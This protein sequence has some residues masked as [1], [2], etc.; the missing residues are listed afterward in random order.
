MIQLAALGSKNALFKFKQKFL[1]SVAI[2]SS[3]ASQF[4]SRSFQALC[5]HLDFFEIES[6]LNS[7]LEKDNVTNEEQELFC[8]SLQSISSTNMDE[9][10][11]VR[12][13]S[14]S[15]EWNDGVVKEQMSNIISTL[16]YGTNISALIDQSFIQRLLSKP[17]SSNWSLLCRLSASSV[18]H[19]VFVYENTK[20]LK[21]LDFDQLIQ[22]HDAVL[23][24]V[25]DEVA[26]Q[27]RAKSP[28]ILLKFTKKFCKR[29]FEK[30]SS[31]FLQ[32]LLGRAEDVLF[33]EVRKVFAFG[34]AVLDDTLS[35]NFV[36]EIKNYIRA[37]VENLNASV[38]VLSELDIFTSHL[39]A[40]S[41]QKEIVEYQLW[42]ICEYFNLRKRLPA[43]SNDELVIE[44][45]IYRIAG[46]A[47]TLFNEGYFDAQSVSVGLVK[48]VL[49]SSLKFR[50]Q[51]A[52]IITLLECLIRKCTLEDP[53]LS[54][55]T[56]VTTHSAF[57]QIIFNKEN[58]ILKT[59]V[60]GL[61]LA[62]ITKD[63]VNC[64]EYSILKKITTAYSGSLS[65]PDLKI[66]EIFRI[67]EEGAN[68]S[69]SNV[70]SC[71]DG[72][73]EGNTYISTETL[74][75]IDSTIMANTIHWFPAECDVDFMTISLTKQV[76][77]SKVQPLYD[78]AFFLPLAGAIVQTPNEQLD[79]HRLLETNVIGLAVAAFSS[80]ILSTRK[81]GHFVLS[82]FYEALTLSSVKEKNQ[83]LLL[84][85]SFRNSIISTNEDVFP[86]VTSIITSFVAQ[87][88][89]ILIKPESDMYPLINRFCLQ[90][91][92]IDI[93]DIPMFYEL[94]YSS[95]DELKKERVWMLRLLLI[96]LRSKQDYQ[97]FHRRHVCNIL[98]AFFQSPLADQHCR[99]LIFEVLENFFNIRL[100][101]RQP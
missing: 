57:D 50:F 71:W 18:C 58:D 68:L 93:Q 24:H 94:F 96:G 4:F 2:G 36:K 45:D 20:S 76:Y 41:V 75:A 25:F 49:I 98:L 92:A 82:G 56:M 55:L 23:N 69:I 15:L 28:D 72:Q 39:K 30:I 8:L 40:S 78:P 52:E 3:N 38:R 90:R 6:I 74:G 27:P 17:L 13:I 87:G 70:L 60:L 42:V 29:K 79:V 101:S 33:I 61:V 43:V 91:A 48:D 97:L 9:K 83:V 19:A 66:M 89:M 7:I 14:K 80:S 95:S 31:R 16:N 64:C 67:Y 99:K 54:V 84:L 65:L 63:L 37:P 12:A 81:L 77:S 11:L 26:F 5:K 51:S 35:E 34:V 46:S 86:Q 73:S 10:M 53:A 88:L 21:S 47:A 1:S 59:A 85:D 62:L 44:K 22:F 100:F 32:A